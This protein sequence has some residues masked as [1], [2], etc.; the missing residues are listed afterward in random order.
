MMTFD[1]DRLPTVEAGRV[2]LRWIE[3]A[4]VPA[5]F[6]VFGDPVV[7]RYWS[8][9]ALED[10]DAARELLSRI[11]DHFRRGDLFQWGVSAVGD[12]ALL[13][14]C[15]LASIDRAHLRAEIGFALS[16]A[17][18]GRGLM[19]NA[20]G[21]LVGLAF[22]ELGLHRLEAEVDPRNAPSIRLLERL[23]FVR[24]GYLRERWQLAGEVQDAIV[25]G[26]LATER[27]GAASGEAR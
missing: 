24:E 14:T 6:S 19:T 22:D 8:E 1:G 7:T 16:R 10:L 13:G 23:G 21:A 12:D 27:A 25:Y 17:H 4:D 9:P 2:R 15:T 11:R 18:Q 3:D 26:L 20:V 5:L